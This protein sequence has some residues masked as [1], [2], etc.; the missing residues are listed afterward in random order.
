MCWS[1][2]CLHSLVLI[3]LW[4]KEQ[5][6]PPILMLISCYWPGNFDVCP[7]ITDVGVCTGCSAVWPG[8]VRCDSMF[9]LN[10]LAGS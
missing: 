9:W 10:Q 3:Y 7:G 2:Q 5:N 4:H 8:G 6:P 1:L